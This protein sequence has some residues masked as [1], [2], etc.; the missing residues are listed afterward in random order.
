MARLVPTIVFAVLS[1][2]VATGQAV[3][4]SSPSPGGPSPDDGTPDA[5]VIDGAFDAED[6]SESL[7]RISHFKTI[8]AAQGYIGQEPAIPVTYLSSIPEG[9]DVNDFG[10]PEYDE[11][12]LGLQQAYVERFSPGRYI[13]VDSP[14]F[15][16]AAIP[17]QIV[18]ELRRLITQA[19][20]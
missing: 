14:H 5:S 3:L 7:E 10:V 11:Q 17:D 1:L 13:R 6:E 12:I 8:S 2:S 9:Y 4:A 18:E 15:M 20:L 19:D 16:E